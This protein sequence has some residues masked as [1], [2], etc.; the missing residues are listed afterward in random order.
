MIMMMMTVTP[1]TT[2]FSGKTVMNSI[3]D[4]AVFVRVDDIG[5][6]EDEERRNKVERGRK[7]EKGRRN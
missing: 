6:G 2:W 3:C 7:T 1:K 4:A 5:I